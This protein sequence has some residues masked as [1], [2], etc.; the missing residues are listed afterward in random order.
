[1]CRYTLHVLFHTHNSATHLTVE[2]PGEKFAAG[3][4]VFLR[5]VV[6]SHF[7]HRPISLTYVVGLPVIDNLCSQ[8]GHLSILM[9]G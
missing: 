6:T 3:L 2:C 1:M 8:S 7:Y 4:T 5:L 9:N